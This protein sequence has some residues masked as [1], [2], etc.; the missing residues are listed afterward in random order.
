MIHIE[1]TRQIAQIAHTGPISH[2]LLT[3]SL[4]TP[5]FSSSTLSSSDVERDSEWFNLKME[6]FYS[7]CLFGGIGTDW[8]CCCDE[9]AKIESDGTSLR[10]SDKISVIKVK[11]QLRFVMS[12]TKFR[13]CV[14]RKSKRTIMPEELPTFLS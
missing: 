1:P 10:F 14:S 3:H 5:S 8:K 2:T 12:Y 6:Q 4:L 13:R 11:M 9:A 7:S